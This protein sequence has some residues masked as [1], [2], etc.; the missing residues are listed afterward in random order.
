MHDQ[1]ETFKLIYVLLNGRYQ[2][3]S[4]ISSRKE[5]TWQNWTFKMQISPYYN[6]RKQQEKPANCLEKMVC[7]NMCWN[8]AAGVVLY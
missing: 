1:P 6:S 5:I 8:V 2:E 4:M 7:I 3:V